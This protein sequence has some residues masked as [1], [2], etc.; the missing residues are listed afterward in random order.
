QLLRPA[1]AVS[2]DCFHGNPSFATILPRCGCNGGGAASPRAHCRRLVRS[3]APPSLVRVAR[4]PSRMRRQSTCRLLQH[5]VLVLSLLQHGDVLIGGFPE[6]EEILV[7]G[8]CFHPISRRR[9]R[10]TQLEP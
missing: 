10:P 6:I 4:Y 7:S 8:L 1:P 5:C 2:P 3:F 9:I